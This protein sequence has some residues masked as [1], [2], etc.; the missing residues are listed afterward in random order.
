M[1]LEITAERDRQLLTAPHSA[2]ARQKGKTMITQNIS[3]GS[4]SEANLDKPK[5]EDPFFWSLNEENTIVRLWP[6][7]YGQ[8]LGYADSWRV[9]NG[10]VVAD[11]G[12][13]SQL[14]PKEVVR[15][16]AAAGI[17]VVQA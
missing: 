15:A 7:K 4:T 11:P 13:S 14:I 16:F 8:I 3:F 5:A 6:G 9:E 1:Y 12:N 2:A 10:K 17:A